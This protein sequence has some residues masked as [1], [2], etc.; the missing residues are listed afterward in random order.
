MNLSMSNILRH[1]IGYDRASFSNIINLLCN[2]KTFLGTSVYVSQ[3]NIQHD[4]NILLLNSTPRIL[5]KDLLKL[6]M[7]EN[8]KAKTSAIKLIQEPM[9]VSLGSLDGLYDPE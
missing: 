1:K 6:K 7:E 4:F 5:C 9:G 3:N 8:P 2:S